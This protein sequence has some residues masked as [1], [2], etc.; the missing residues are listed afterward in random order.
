MPLSGPVAR[1]VSRHAYAP[2]L[3]NLAGHDCIAHYVSDNWTVGHLLVSKPYGGFPTMLTRRVL[4]AG[5]AANLVMGM[6]E[7][8]YEAVAGP[9]C[10]HR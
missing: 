8:L 6:F 7:T 9:A 2:L 10:G 3:V 4:L 5:L 1:G